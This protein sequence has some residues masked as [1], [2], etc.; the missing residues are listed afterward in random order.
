MRNLIGIDIEEL[1]RFEDKL[2]G[3]FI[4]RNLYA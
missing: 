2:D 3:K 1:D 4:E